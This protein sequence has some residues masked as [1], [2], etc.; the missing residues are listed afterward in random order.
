MNDYEIILEISNRL[1]IELIDAN[2]LYNALLDTI[3]TELINKGTVKLND[4]GNFKV[5][6]RAAKKGYNAY[7]KKSIDIPACLAPVFI[8]GKKLKELI[9]NADIKFE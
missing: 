9:A 7:Y 1:N 3:K 5:V 4:F 2:K 8:P 6:H